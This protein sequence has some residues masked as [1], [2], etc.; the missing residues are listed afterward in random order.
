MASRPALDKAAWQR[1]RKA[2]RRRDGEACRNCGS[3]ARLSVHHLLPAALGGSDDMSNLITLC[4]VCHPQF[5]QAART[6]TLPVDTPPAPKRTPRR[7]KSEHGAR[8]RGPDGQPWS[9]QWYEY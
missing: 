1:T 7:R 5:E 3:T 2:V 6:L 9:R 4:G 8:F